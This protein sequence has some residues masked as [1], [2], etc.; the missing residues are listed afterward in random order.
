[1]RHKT[2]ILEKARALLE[3]ARE[4]FVQKRTACHFKNCKHN[5]ALVARTVGKMHYCTLHT[6]AS[7]DT[8]IEKLFICDNDEWACKCSDYC[9]RNTKEDAEKAFVQIIANPSR[10]G[11]LFPRLSAL[12]WVLNDGRHKEVSLP[13]DCQDSPPHGHEK[14]EEESEG[15]SGLFWGLIH[16]VRGG[17]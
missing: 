16:R 14:N 6:H 9:C 5:E 8:K 13:S 1:M 2:E 10:C 17:R 11:Q 15:N 7:E 3:G 12:L 4:D